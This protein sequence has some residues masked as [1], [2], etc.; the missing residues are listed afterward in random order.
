M[1]DTTPTGAIDASAAAHRPRTLL[2]VAQY[3]VF[4]AIIGGLWLWNS[5]EPA[6]VHALR[7]ALFVVV[8][9][10]VGYWRAQKLRIR[11][12]RPPLPQ[13]SLVRIIGA[14]LALLVVALIVSYLITPLTPHTDQF[15]AAGLFLA[16]VVG[17]PL[18]HHL[19]VR[20]A[21]DAA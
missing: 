9:L 4:G 21:R 1:N 15:I 11:R 20:P 13:L 10:P 6:W 19:F 18:C 14:K 2:V 17:G 8:V 5:G 12:G 7:T 3:A 16:V